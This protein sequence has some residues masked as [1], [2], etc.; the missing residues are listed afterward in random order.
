MLLSFTANTT[1]GSGRGR[2]LGSPTVNLALDD[3]PE[4]LEEGIYAVRVTFDGQSHSGAMH[5][6]PRPAVKGDRAC[7]VHVIDAA[8][9][10]L[11]ESV[12]VDVVERIRDIQDFDSLDA[13]TAQ[14]RADLDV[15]R[16]ILSSE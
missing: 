8:I 4:L 13:L 6:G 10:D 3:V 16:E 14:I 11:P 7:E 2:E 1:R 15:A 5:Y 9:K 12:T